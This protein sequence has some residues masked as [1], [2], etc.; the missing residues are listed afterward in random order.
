MAATTRTQKMGT[1]TTGTMVDAEVDL[2]ARICAVGVIIVGCRH[3][4][5]RALSFRERGVFIMDI[6]TSAAR[7]CPRH[8][9]RWNVMQWRMKVHGRRPPAMADDD[10][11]G[12][13]K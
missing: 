11:S 9:C 7:L 8:I 4:G 5:R 3:R 12:L 6:G 2:G 10:M 13:E 1:T